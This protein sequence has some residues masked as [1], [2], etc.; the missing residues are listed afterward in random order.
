MSD[1]L[2]QLLSG[3]LIL[4]IGIIFKIFPPGKINHFYGYRGRRIMKP[5]SPLNLC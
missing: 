2:I 4:I 5:N 3:P 1:I